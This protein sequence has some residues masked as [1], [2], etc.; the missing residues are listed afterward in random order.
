MEMNRC[1][2]CFAGCVILATC[3]FFAVRAYGA[4][5]GEAQSIAG[6]DRRAM[7]VC[8][9]GN[10]LFV[11]SGTKLYAFDI[12]APLVPR[13]MSVLDGFDNARQIVVQDGFVYVVSRETG[14]RIV[15]A[16]D[17]AHMRIRSRFDTVEFATGIDV[18][19]SVAFV[20]ERINGVECVDV[21]DP[22]RP[23]HICIRKTSESQS[24]R[25]RDGWLYS[26]E[27]GN[28]S[29]TVFDARDMRNFHAVA[30]LDL[31]GYGDGVEIDGDYLYC[32]T[33][34][35]SRHTELK[36][37]EAIGRGRG[38]DIFSIR[39]P[40]R[41]EWVARVDFP[42]FKPRS[43]DY[44]TP[45]VSNGLAF[46]CD[47]HNGL[48]VVDVKEPSRPEV[49]DRFC[50]PQSGKDWPSGAI[51][52]LAVG[53]GCIY[54]TSNP[55]GLFVIPVHGVRPY[56]PS[57][58]TPPVHADF[59]E[60]YPTDDSQFH[61]WKPMRPGQART[62]CVTNDIVYAACGDA[63]LH[64][65]RIKDVGGFE[66]I[67]GLPENRHAYDC[68]MSDG[69]LVVAEGLA[70]FAVYELDGYA[71][72]REVARRKRLSESAS[73]ACWVWPTVGKGLIFS[74]RYGGYNFFSI[75]D[76]N[77]YRPL[78]TE[79]GSCQ[80]DKYVCDGAI[81]GTLPILVPYRGVLWFDVGGKKPIQID[82]KR[83]PRSNVG[84]QRNGICTFGNDAFLQT[85]E[86]GYA[87]AGTNR[88]FGAV[89]PLPSGGFSGMPRSDGRWVALTGRSERRIAVF[90]FA[91]AN[92]PV[93]D[94][95]YRVSGNPDVA[96]F[97]K[98]RIIVPCG[99][100]GV[101]MEKRIRDGFSR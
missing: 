2:R 51:S 3:T 17:S 40:S 52:S 37:E 100:Q 80:W 64:V 10:R 98:G 70:G 32:S 88:V 59:R 28:G 58:G 33:G 97:H 89:R 36:G 12:S 60:E 86:S 71:G 69:R 34:H 66:R 54:V 31:H 45:R 77:A 95:T 75:E 20:C 14:L 76:I 78:L 22:D 57:K 15:D 39:N 23:A 87:L 61:V 6:I 43:D 47:S 18:V 24:C 5:L 85:I 79:S 48:F 99:H 67:G 91:D 7:S 42:R 56:V 84:T 55:G 96:A 94:C 35:D 101:L 49:V 11:A 74:G 38:M 30:N 19:G 46:C 1:V 29:V 73:V 50:V 82:F 25:Y 26:G 41:P 63:G 53:E 27:W 90:D 62:V 13:L 93:L 65:L 8:L 81:R 9:E 83:E 16:R 21:S 92:R 44:W 4:V 72:F 68:A